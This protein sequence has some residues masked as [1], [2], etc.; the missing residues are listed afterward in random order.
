MCMEK[1][2][3]KGVAD[4]PVGAPAQAEQQQPRL[5]K[6]P[7]FLAL[8]TADMEQ[9][10][11]LAGIG[12]TSGFGIKIGKEFFTAH[13]PQGVEAIVSLTGPGACPL[14]LD[15]KW[16]DIPNTVAGA[17][18]ACEALAP[19]FLTLHASGGPAMIEAAKAA[20]AKAK[21]PPLLLAV[22]MLTSLDDDDLRAIGFAGGRK[23][24]VMRLARMAIDAGA[25]GLVIGADEIVAMRAEFGPA[26]RLVVPG[27]RVKGSAADDQKQT[28][29][30]GDA[31]RLGADFLVVGRAIVKAAD[32]DSAARRLAEEVE[33]AA[34]GE[35][36][37]TAG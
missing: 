14:F 11:T 19:L 13:G 27:I 12:V 33:A 16:H 6:L 29:R 23:K 2:L 30:A 26:A 10:K 3:T 25:D 18:R 24:G 32:P 20:A 37:R 9:A 8:D 1:T 5:P 34:A 7:V 35:R 31:L 36:E 17:V 28:A 15:L 22:T 21:E 4:R